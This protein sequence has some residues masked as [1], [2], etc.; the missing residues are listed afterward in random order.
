MPQCVVVAGGLGSRLLA[1]GITTPKILLEIEGRPLLSHIVEEVLSE[2]YTKILFCLGI[3]S[4]Q[5]IA[6]I[7]AMD[8]QI[9]IDISVEESQL[10]TLGAL[11]QARN[12]LEDFFTVLMGDTYISCTN[13]GSIHLLCESLD[14]H[15]LTLCKFTDHPSDSDLVEIDEYGR[16]S[17]I[18]R[19]NSGASQP[20]YNIGLA[21]VCFLSKELIS[22]DSNSASRDITRDLFMPAI[23]NGDE[24]QALFHQGVIRDLGTPE[25]LTSFL[26]DKS[27]SSP[28]T[29]SNSGNI[30]L[31]DRDGTLNVINGHISKLKDVSINPAGIAIAR[32]VKDENLQAFLITNQPVISRGEAL[33]EDIHDIC[34]NLLKTLEIWQGDDHVY[35]CPHYPEAGFV[36]ENRKLKI[37]CDC[38]K[39][40]PGLLL[41][42]GNEHKFRLTNAIMVGDSL[43]DVYAGLRVGAR[44]IHLHEKLDLR[45]D[46]A[47][48]LGRLV[49][50]SYLNELTME[51]VEIGKVI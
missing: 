13:I 16:I 6:A 21:G 10:G 18:Y 4:E 44:V 46:F 24:I 26:E 51:L 11:E 17:R 45:C 35:I 12:F 2:G 42:A 36:G 29:L 50:C 37:R 19:G 7:R 28:S 27:P 1:G 3:E 38:R 23:S 43:T 48:P 14:L 20:E 33:A 30:M 32:K 31:L 39:P 41:R 15:A 8:I 9:Q 40:N 25:R 49:A 34:V 22:S 5:I 47:V